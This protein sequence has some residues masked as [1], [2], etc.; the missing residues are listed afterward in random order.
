MLVQIQ[1]FEKNE[2]RNADTSILTMLQWV[3]TNF[4]MW[5]FYQVEKVGT[6]HFKVYDKFEGNKLVYE[7]TKAKSVKQTAKEV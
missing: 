7:I 2:T 4:C 1:D 6:N 5:G 3:K